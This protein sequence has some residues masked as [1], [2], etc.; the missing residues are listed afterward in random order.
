MS[1]P[2]KSPI[3]VL[4]AD[5]YLGWPLS[6]RLARK[7]PDRDI[8]LVDNF[9]RRRLVREVGSD[10]IL[11]VLE[12]EQRLWACKKHYN[13]SNMSFVHMDVNSPA[14]D[15]LISEHRPAAIYHLAQQCSAPFSMK[16]VENALLTGSL[17]PPLRAARI[18]S[19]GLRVVTT[20][21]RQSPPP[22]SVSAKSRPS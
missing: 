19:R 2:Q 13:L 10:S 1:Q 4:G 16:N 17:Q 3:I 18:D 11:P 21:S 14:L 7:N 20:A 22:Q 5:G 9:L 12:I 8:I 15:L 6:L